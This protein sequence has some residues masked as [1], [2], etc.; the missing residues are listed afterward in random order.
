MV[1]EVQVKNYRITFLMK[2]L[3]TKRKFEVDIRA[4]TE[5]DA[6]EKAYSR[7][8]SK[9]RVP[10]Q[11]LKLKNIKEIKASDLKDPILQTIATE[12]NIKI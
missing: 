1:K 6:I 11:L 2:P 7:I 4:V 5:E 10:R 9:H 8:G 3:T 12:D